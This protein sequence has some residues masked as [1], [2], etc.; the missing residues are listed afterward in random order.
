MRKARY[1]RYQ[2]TLALFLKFYHLLESCAKKYHGYSKSKILQQNSRHCNQGA[3]TALHKP[4][5]CSELPRKVVQA[6][7]ASDGS[8]DE[9]VQ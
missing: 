9:F 4:Q 1:S 5:N 3:I 7:G 8:L 6:A 2:L